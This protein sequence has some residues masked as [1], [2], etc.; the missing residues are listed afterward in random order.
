MKILILTHPLE[1]NYGGILQNYAL[2]K[3]LRNQGHDVRTIDFHNDK[4][5]LY[6][7][8]SFFLRLLR[9]FALRQKNI[10]ISYSINK[11]GKDKLKYNPDVKRFIE[12]NITITKYIASKRQLH[13]VLNLKPEC[14]L[15]GSDQVW[16]KEFV[17]GS[18]LDFAKHYNCIKIAYAASGDIEW[19]RTSNIKSE[20]KC[21]ISKF[22]AVSVRELSNITKC[23]EILNL[24]P[25]I[26]LDPVF[27]L[28]K[29]EYLDF[30]F[31]KLNY[32][33]TLTTYLLDNTFEKD[34]FVKKTASENGLKINSCTSGENVNHI[35]S[36]ETWLSSIAYSD[37]I[38]TD[39][40]HGMV[41]S[42]VFNK[43]FVVIAN[44]K[45]GI[46]RFR[47]VLAYF[48]LENRLIDEA[49][50]S[51]LSCKNLIPID[52]SRVNHTI[53]KFKIASFKFLKDAISDK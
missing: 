9:R 7:V 26:V 45:R 46:D 36:I 6:R 41:L 16:Q 51:L 20:L 18:F 37:Y 27:L 11:S 31:G 2:Q 13:K 35:P 4:S 29:K 52:Y 25:S 48:G 30:T 42:I 10:P 53:E 5:F 1:T 40:F 50:L 38:I 22:D 47:T 34:E 8:A 12:N 21:L 44:V 32:I 28:D 33:S 17:P 23:E 19:I 39:S 43:D 14:I 49:K 3:V 15:V 24:K